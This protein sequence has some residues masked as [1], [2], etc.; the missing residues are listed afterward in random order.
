[1]TT[2]TLNER[3]QSCHNTVAAYS[4]GDGRDA[5]RTQPCQCDVFVEVGS[6]FRGVLP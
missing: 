2:R 3:P 5:T 1:M 4:F 6:S